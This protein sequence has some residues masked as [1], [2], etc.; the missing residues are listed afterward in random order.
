MSTETNNFGSASDSHLL[1]L[2][3]LLFNGQILFVLSFLLTLTLIF[4]LCSSIVLTRIQ[5]VL[6]PE[7]MSPLVPFDREALLGGSRVDLDS[8][9][10]TSVA[11]FLSVCRSPCTM[12]RCL[13]V[14]KI[15]AKMLGLQSAVL[16]VGAGSIFGLINLWL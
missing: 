6:L 5:A 12:E 2:A 16:L 7:E 1:V 10:V 11:R 14:G 8:S 3:L 13:R 4:L 9:W 15:Y